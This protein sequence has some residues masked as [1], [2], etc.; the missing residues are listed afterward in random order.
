MS[1]YVDS[2]LNPLLHMIPSYIKDTTHFLRI[3][4]SIGQVP[5]DTLL[6]TMDVSSLYSN[7][8]HVEGI[9]AIKEFMLKHS[10][11]QM[12]VTDTSHIIDF[13]LNNNYFSFNNKFYLQT[14]GTAMCTKMAPSYANIFMDKLESDMIDSF[15]PK[16]THYH[17]YIDDI[18]FSYGRMAKPR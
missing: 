4:D 6:V 12:T 14:K 18:F 10:F 13:I 15:N 16:P 1:G 11:D 8:P 9:S 5:K 17:R 2:L 3:I 7:I